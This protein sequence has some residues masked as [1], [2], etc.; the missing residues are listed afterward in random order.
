[1]ATPATETSESTA[2]P[3]ESQSP[4]AKSDSNIRLAAKRNDVL[5]AKQKKKRDAHQIAI[6]R[7]HTSG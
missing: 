1:M 6:R 2:T 7:S 3:A 5:K 4:S